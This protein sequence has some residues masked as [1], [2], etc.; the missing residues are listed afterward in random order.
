MIQ[1]WSIDCDV[2]EFTRHLIHLIYE[3][4]FHI[5]VEMHLFDVVDALDI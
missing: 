4:S 1:C 3:F 5:Y 2:F